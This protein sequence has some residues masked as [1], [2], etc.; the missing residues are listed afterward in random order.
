MIDLQEGHCLQHRR[1]AG[2]LQVG[3]RLG[4]GLVSRPLLGQ[5]RPPLRAH[6][7]LHPTHT[8]LQEVLKSLLSLEL[9]SNIEEVQYP[10]HIQ[11]DHGG[12]RL[13]FVDSDLGVPPGCQ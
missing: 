3:A 9:F 2:H 13:D 8:P 5:P 7:V 6:A 12:L 4:R 1:P 11:C 10:N